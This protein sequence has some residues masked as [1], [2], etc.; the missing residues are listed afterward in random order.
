MKHA[1]RC[2]KVYVHRLCKV[3][4]EEIS[5][6][7]A[8]PCDSRLSARRRHWGNDDSPGNFVGAAANGSRWER[9]QDYRRDGQTPRIRTAVAGVNP[10]PHEGEC[11]RGAVSQRLPSVAAPGNVTGESTFSQCRRRADR[12][13]SLASSDLRL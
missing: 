6:Q 13:L 5:R 1:S 4:V 11:C 10:V 3:Y 8:K 2:V 12:Q 7:K 9:D